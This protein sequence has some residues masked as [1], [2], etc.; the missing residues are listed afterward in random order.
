MGVTPGEHSPPDQ[1]RTAG[2]QRRH[3]LPLS[4]PSDTLRGMDL[5]SCGYCKEMVDLS[6]DTHIHDP[7][8]CKQCGETLPAEAFD[9][10]PSSADGRRHT[11]SQ[12]VGNEPAATRAQRVIEKDKQLRDHKEKLKEHGYRWVQLVVQS[13][14]DPFLRGALLDP[15]GQEVSKEHALVTLGCRKPGTQRLPIRLTGIR[16]LPHPRRPTESLVL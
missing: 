10:W 11:C 14:P 5:K 8:K 1:R 16:Q 3:H 6:G 15:Q 4:G 12:C 9:R 7:K 13:G 2:C